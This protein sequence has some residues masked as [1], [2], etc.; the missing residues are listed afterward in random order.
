MI[1]MPTVIAEVAVNAA[2]ASDGPEVKK[3]SS[4]TQNSSNPAASAATA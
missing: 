4:M 3:Q 1:P 2:A